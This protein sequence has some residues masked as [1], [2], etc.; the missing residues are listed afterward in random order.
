MAGLTGVRRVRDEIE[1]DAG[2]ADSIDVTAL[3]RAALD[4]SALIHDDSEVLVN[5][6]SNT[7]NTVMLT[8][9]V[10]T[11][12]EHDAVVDAAWMASGVYDVIDNLTIIS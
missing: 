5:T 3:V 2:V 10:C 9:H 12:A 1:I 7:G 8:G 11:W 4:R 6:S